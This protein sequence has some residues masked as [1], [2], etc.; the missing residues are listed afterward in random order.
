MEP[1]SAMR[2]IL[3]HFQ[4]FAALVAEPGACGKTCG[5]KTGGSYA[6][7]IFCGAATAGAFLGRLEVTEKHRFVV[8][9]PFNIPPACSCSEMHSLASFCTAMQQSSYEKV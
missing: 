4:E 5:R 1:H 2:A 6:D 8:L 9:T 3:P 7:S